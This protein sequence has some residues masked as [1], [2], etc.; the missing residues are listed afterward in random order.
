MAQVDAFRFLARLSDLFA[1]NIQDNQEFIAYIDGDSNSLVIQAD[2]IIHASGGS[3][4]DT[5]QIN[6]ISNTLSALKDQADTLESTCRDI[7][8]LATQIQ[9]LSGDSSAGTNDFAW[10]D[11]KSELLLLKGELLDFKAQVAE[12]IASIKSSS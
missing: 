6:E 12:E 3:S 10:A 9:T 5:S 8:A 1:P 4:L 11:I 7:P 2:N